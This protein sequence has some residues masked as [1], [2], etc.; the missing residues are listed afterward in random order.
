MFSKNYEIKY[1]EIDTQMVL[2]PSVLFEYLEDIA[3]KNAD[4]IGFGYDDITRRGYAWFLL[5]YTMEFSNYPQNILG[6][7]I[8]TEPRGANRLFAYRDFAI[9]DGENDVIGRVN[10]TWGLIDINTK[11]MVNPQT[12]FPQMAPL[13]K[14]E[15]DLK[16]TKIPAITELSAEKTFHV[17]YDDIDVNQHVNNSNYILWAFEAL[18]IEFRSSKK[19]KKLDLTYKKEVKYGNNIVSKVQ[20]TDNTTIHVIKNASTDEEL[21]SILAQWV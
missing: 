5:K 9:K 18:P 20:I 19:L 16:Y 11:S 12:A 8:E 15:D 21:C 14:R 17:R 6:L 7:K 3:A 13:E 2:K 10:S 1:H 4:T